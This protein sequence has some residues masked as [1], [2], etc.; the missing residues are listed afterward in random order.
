MASQ[1]SANARTATGPFPLLAA[2]LRVDQTFGVLDGCLAAI[3]TLM[4]VS[5]RPA[6]LL[7]VLFLCLTT[8]AMYWRLPGFAGRSLVWVTLA[9]L[10]MFS[11]AA[12]GTVTM[13]ELVQLPLLS[14]IL[15]LVFLLARQ[16]ARMASRLEEIA[17][18]DPLTGLP[19]RDRFMQGFEQAISSAADQGLAIAILS[20][21]LDGLKTINDAL[22]HEAG[23]QVLIETAKRL[24]GAVRAD[25]LVA[26]IGGDEFMILLKAEATTIPRIV[27]RIIEAAQ[28]PVLLAGKPVSVTVSAGVALSKQPALR[29]RDA[30]LRDADAALQR[31]KA[32]G[33]AGYEVFAPVA[34]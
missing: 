9:S 24:R 32:A 29:Q 34:A 4:F 30:I 2:F 5:D 16:R 26:R 14:A 17:G 10:A 6:T 20:I 27:E 28:Q 21:D 7:H 13:Q 31:V 33:K 15:L 11:G 19:G 22:G 18:C 23:D 3:A 25:D 1:S 12:E 8:G